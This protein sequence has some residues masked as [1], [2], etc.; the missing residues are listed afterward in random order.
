MGSARGPS[1]R[2]LDE[3]VWAALLADPV[4]AATTSASAKPDP[5]GVRE[6]MIPA[7]TQVDSQCAGT[8]GGEQ[9]QAA[10]ALIAGAFQGY[11]AEDG[12]PDAV[13]RINA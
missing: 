4:R 5:F 8:G 13:R 10:L 6:L 7:G 3:L 2:L 11:Q 9:D 12:L 1:H